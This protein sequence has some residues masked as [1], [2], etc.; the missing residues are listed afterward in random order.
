MT[1]VVLVMP[2]VLMEVSMCV[3]GN[4]GDDCSDVG[5]CYVEQ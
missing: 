3:S 4:D 2:M 5:C 1:K